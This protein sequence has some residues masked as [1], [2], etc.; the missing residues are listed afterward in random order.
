MAWPAAK[1]SSKYAEANVSRHIRGPCRIATEWK[2]SEINILSKEVEVCIYCG[3]RWMNWYGMKCVQHIFICTNGRSSHSV[4]ISSLPLHCPLPSNT[5]RLALLA[6]H[7]LLIWPIIGLRGPT[8]R[9]F[10][11]MR[12]HAIS[13]V[14]WIRMG[15]NAVNN[16]RSNQQS[17][18]LNRTHLSLEICL[19]GLFHRLLEFLSF[20]SYFFFI[21]SF[22]LFIWLFC[23]WWASRHVFFE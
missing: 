22:F 20:V 15:V 16:W 23:F 17:E 2:S 9:R 4:A 12:V 11:S 5:L 6:S 21:I 14:N 1:F 7:P 18:F 10:D 19:P 13:Y 3:V 8:I